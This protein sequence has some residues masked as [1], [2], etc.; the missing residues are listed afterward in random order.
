[1][2]KLKRFA[3]E[4]DFK[5]E[6]DPDALKEAL[7]AGGPKIKP[8]HINED[9][10]Y[11]PISP[12]DN[13]YGKFDTDLDES[14]Y[15]IPDERGTAFTKMIRL[16]LIY[17]MLRAPTYQ[18]GCGLEISKLIFKKRM[19]SFF[20]LHNRVVTEQLM[21]IAQAYDCFPWN[22]P[23]EDYR[24]Y[25][26]EKIALYSVFVG[27]YS[28]WLII[29][30]LIGLVFQLVVAGTGDFS[31]PSLPFYSLIV[32]LWSIFMLEYW[33]RQ[34]AYSSMQWGMSEFEAEEPER[35]EFKG[36]PIKSYITGKDMLYYPP[37]EKNDNLCVSASVVLSY[38]LL[39][40]GV[41]VSIYI[42][43]FSIQGDVGVWASLMASVLNT[44]QIV[45]FNFIYRSVV[46]QLTDH[47]NPRTDTIYED[48]MIVKL[49]LFQFVNSYS[50]FFFVAFIAGNLDT[51]D[52]TANDDPQGECGAPTCMQP[53]AINLAII[54]GTRLT[55]TNFLDIFMPYLSYK[56]KIKKETAGVEDP[57]KLTPAELDYMLMDYD[58]IVE[59]IQNYADTAIQFGFL[60]LFITALP[61]AG[62]FALISNYVKT[63]LNLWKLV[64]FYQRPVPNGA[65]DMG[66]WLIIFQG[67]ST[68]AVITNGGL[69]CFTMDVLPFG[70]VYKIWI[71]ILFQWCLISL[72]VLSQVLVE[73]VPSEVQIQLDRQ[74]FYRSKVID[75]IEDD[76]AEA[77]VSEDG[78]DL[79]EEQAGK[80]MNDPNRCTF[81]GI[82]FHMMVC[83]R[84]HQPRY[85]LHRNRNYD[86]SPPVEVKGYPHGGV[87]VG[88]TNPGGGG[89][90]A[91]IKY[92]NPLLGSN[93]VKEEP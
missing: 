7:I 51:S 48:S 3:D 66:T 90:K 85:N 21:G 38:M 33:K 35:P 30:G 65:Q 58:G 61:C 79:V 41:V 31:S 70:L 54:F 34:E 89:P 91:T 2:A 75:K 82:T 53:L 86:G 36:H 5:L 28:R 1:M 74:A 73:D 40:L 62:F 4:I 46:Q 68:A 37:E 71:F 39:V 88:E 93:T 14:L 45:I 59:G 22:M 32:C 76:E 57:T 13:I 11:T 78:V 49:F 15:A 29:P 55:L 47:E 6:L 12:Y 9:M 84:K 67:L 50:S 63:K 25:F 17:Y 44:I 60:M 27:H 18:G 69:I 81:C 20:P 10:K 24:Q 43:R 16:K 80:P 52:D 72:Q 26:G 77:M 64:T 83:C 8:I 19:L 87:A 23:F 92:M 56:R 42:M